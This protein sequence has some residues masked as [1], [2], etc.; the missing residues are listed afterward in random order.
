MPDGQ[1]LNRRAY[2]GQQFGQGSSSRAQLPKEARPIIVPGKH[3]YLY[4]LDK[5]M[6]RKISRLALPYPG[7]SGL[8]SETLSPPERRSGAIPENRS[9]QHD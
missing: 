1:V 9:T 2:T 6:R 3:R 7:G 8:N 4:P 5:A